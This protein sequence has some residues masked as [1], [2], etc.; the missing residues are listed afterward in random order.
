MSITKEEKGKIK[1]FLDMISKEFPI[2]WDRITEHYEVDEE[3]GDFYC[4]IV[5]GWIHNIKRDDFIVLEISKSKYTMYQ[6]TPTNFITS[7]VKY[8]KKLSK[9]LKFETH[10]DCI[11]YEDFF[12]DI[13]N[14]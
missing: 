14:K 13:D 4:I 6:L 9:K 5:F 3:L 8:T 2:I 11:K 10:D 1:E 12:V 7:S